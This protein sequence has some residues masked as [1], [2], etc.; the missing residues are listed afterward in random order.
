MINSPCAKLMTRIMPKITLRPRATIT[1]VEMFVATLSAT[2]RIW[3]GLMEKGGR[4]P[5]RPPP[6]RYFVF[7]VY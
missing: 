7:G 6:D 5:S 1:R 3:S 4:R 2:T